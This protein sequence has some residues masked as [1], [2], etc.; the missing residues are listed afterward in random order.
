M[1]KNTEKI[2]V[3]GSNIKHSLSPLIHNAIFE[4]DGI[5]ASYEIIDIPHDNLTKTRFDDLLSQ[6]RGLNITSPFKT[7][8]ADLLYDNSNESLD[9]L[10]LSTKSVNTVDI[11]PENGVKGYNTDIAGF[12]HGVLDIMAA[13]TFIPTRLILLGAGGVARSVIYSFIEHYE[14]YSIRKIPV[15]IV[16]L[17]D[18]NRNSDIV[19]LVTG[20]A[21]KGH[22]IRLQFMQWDDDEIAKALN[23]GGMVVNASPLGSASRIDDY[24]FN[25]ERENFKISRPLTAVDLV[26]NPA[27]TLF[28]KSAQKKKVRTIGGLGM[29]VYQA[30]DSQKIWREE[31]VSEKGIFGKLESNSYVWIK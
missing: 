31:K 2:A 28:L 18:P 25:F 4:R 19:D 30:L 16:F 27:E 13:M 12:R 1:L 23:M 14:K 22:K 17:R 8:V 3:I 29:L 7:I 10:A 21:H 11:H 20:I 26:Y 9:A 24:S 5:N 6:Y 15:I